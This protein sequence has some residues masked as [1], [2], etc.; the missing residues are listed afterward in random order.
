MTTGFH[1]KH[2]VCLA[3][4]FELGCVLVAGINPKYF[5]AYDSRDVSGGTSLDD[6]RTVG[7]TDGIPM[8]DPQV[9]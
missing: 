4:D 1:A 3:Q 7:R 9:I 6:T 5:G 2:S 8:G